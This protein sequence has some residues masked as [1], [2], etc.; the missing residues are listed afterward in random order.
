MCGRVQEWE[1]CPPLSGTNSEA[2]M[3]LEG[4]AQ[5]QVQTKSLSEGQ[6]SGRGIHTVQCAG[7]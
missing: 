4:S 1:G 3:G 7:E 6:A 5:G 2:E